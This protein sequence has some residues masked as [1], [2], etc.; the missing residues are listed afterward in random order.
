[1][2]IEPNP[3]RSHERT[4]LLHRILSLGIS[5]RFFSPHLELVASCGPDCDIHAS[6]LFGPLPRRGCFHER[7][8]PLEAAKGSHTHRHAHPLLILVPCEFDHEP[9]ETNRAAEFRCSSAISKGHLPVT[10]DVVHAFVFFPRKEN[11]TP[12]GVMNTLATCTSL[13]SRIDLLRL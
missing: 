6:S 13:R 10:P 9:R 8:Y 7:K 2:R 4:I 1:M 11:G 3:Y 12:T 5:L